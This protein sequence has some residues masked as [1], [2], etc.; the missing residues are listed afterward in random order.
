MK[1]R[2]LFFVIIA[3][4]TEKSFVGI[5]QNGNHRKNIRKPRKTVVSSALLAMVADDN[6][7]SQTSGTR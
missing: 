1:L 7:A 4:L 3:S 6:E 5:E 2:Q